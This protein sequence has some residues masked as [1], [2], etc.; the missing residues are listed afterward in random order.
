MKFI[1]RI[2]KLFQ[3]WENENLTDENGNH[4]DS[5]VTSITIRGWSADYYT[6]TTLDE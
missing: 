4:I 6:S 2:K 5:W 3:R 1:Q